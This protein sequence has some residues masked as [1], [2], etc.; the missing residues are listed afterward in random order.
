MNIFSS[1]FLGIVQGL[2][3]F[4]P[5]SSSGHLVFFQKLIPGFTQP[6]VLFDAVLHTIVFYSKTKDNETLYF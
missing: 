4:L 3:E 6:G 2:T 1:T 5:V